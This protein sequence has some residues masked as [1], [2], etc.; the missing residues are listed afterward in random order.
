VTKVDENPREPDRRYGPASDK[1]ATHVLYEPDPQGETSPR[2]KAVHYFTPAE[3]AARGKAAR[4]ELPRSV[5]GT[6]EP[7]PR[8]P[9][10]P[11]GAWSVLLCVA[12]GYLRQ[13]RRRERNPQTDA[14]RTPKRRTCLVPGR[15]K[16]RFPEHTKRQQ[17]YT[18]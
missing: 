6:W 2:L 7:R 17:G 10:G 15:A 8:A 14:Q 4:A 11:D 3:R 16:D 13:E 12:L 1:A 9:Q 18:S 5:H